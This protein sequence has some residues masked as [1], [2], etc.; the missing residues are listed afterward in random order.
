MKLCEGLSYY[1]IQKTLI[2]ALKRSLF[3]QSDKDVKS[4]T[5]IDS[6]I[7]KALVIAEKKSLE[8]NS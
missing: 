4:I 8:I 1:S 7:W 6:Q 3:K 5:K 2:T